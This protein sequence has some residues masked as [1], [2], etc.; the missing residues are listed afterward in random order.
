MA[1]L[2]IIMSYRI[3]NGNI[4]LLWPISF[5]KFCLPTF[6]GIFYGQIFLLL[7]TIFDCQDGFSYVSQDL[8]CRS[9]QWFSIETPLTIIAII[10]HAV[11]A[12]MKNTLYYKSIY[13]KKGSDILKKTNC[14]SD[15]ALLLTK[16]FVNLIF[17]LEDKS[18]D[19]HWAILFFLILFTGLNLNCVFYYQSRQNKK[20]DFLNK[21]L[22]LL[23]FLGFFSL[24][25]GKIFIFLG[26]NG[27]I[28]MFFTWIILGI[29][30]ILFYRKKEIDFV[31]INYREIENTEIFISYV[32]T[33][34]EI[35]T[36]REF[37]RKDYTILK[38]LISKKEE[39]CFD[40][41]C[42]LKKYE[43]S[44]GEDNIFPLLQYCERLFEFG[45]SKFPKDISLKVN[46]STFL[47]FEMNNNKNALIILNNIH[48]SIFSYHK[49]YNI[50]R[51]KKLKNK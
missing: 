9:G 3:R 25:V 42:P 48:N 41:Q 44:P 40:S 28:F 35:I 10:L 34:Y 23:P 30:F 2:I 6:S 20:L 51:C 46:Y 39:N 43:N 14:N 27:A 32:N 11:M 12:L 26:F 17:I 4:K 47:I 49:N 36:N 37:C 33:F 50:Y 22:C 15:L 38:S 19:S 24:F 16:I 8:V 13:V 1:I 31:S 21:I 45:I 7:T 29:I 18:E 5:L